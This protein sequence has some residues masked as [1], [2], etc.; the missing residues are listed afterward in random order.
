MLSQDGSAQRPGAVLLSAALQ[1]PELAVADWPATALSA[2]EVRQIRNGQTILRAE[3]IGE[4][5]RAHAPDGS[6]LALL[7]RADDRWKPVKVFDW[8]S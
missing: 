6:L 8:T 3:L 1:P 4:R 2:D 7:T 5:A